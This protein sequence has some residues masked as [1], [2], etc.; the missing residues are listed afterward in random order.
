MVLYTQV[1]KQTAKAV[2]SQTAANRFS[3]FGGSNSR[4]MEAYATGWTSFSV[5]NFLPANKILDRISKAE[6]NGHEYEF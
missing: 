2:L 4:M 6:S 5:D 3:D 1:Y